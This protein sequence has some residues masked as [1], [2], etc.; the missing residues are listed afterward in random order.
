MQNGGK[1]KA[2]QNQRGM[3]PVQSGHG[4]S[5]LLRR[6]SGGPAPRPAAGPLIHGIKIIFSYLLHQCGSTDM[7]AF[8]RPSY[9]PS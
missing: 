1:V 9:D 8:S 7:Q 5:Q 3:E 2:R 6:V 4:F